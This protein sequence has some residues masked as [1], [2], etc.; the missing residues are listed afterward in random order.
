[1][2]QF[3]LL[4]TPGDSMSKLMREFFQWV[5][6]R[7]QVLFSFVAVDALL[8][9]LFIWIPIDIAVAKWLKC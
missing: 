1:M 9:E 6:T 2:C 4:F 8:I 3:A 7:N 5:K